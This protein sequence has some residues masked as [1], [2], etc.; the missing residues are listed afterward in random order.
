MCFRQGGDAER[1]RIE[2]EKRLNDFGLELALE[3][4][5]VMEFGPLARIQAK[6]K[7]KK[8]ATFDFLG[9]THYCSRTRD[10]RRFRMKRKTISKR[11]AAKVKAVKEWLKLNRT[12][13]TAELM[14]KLAAKLNGHYA[15]YGVT[16][17]SR[18]IANFYYVVC[19]L[20]HEW[21]NRRGKRG[22]YNWAKFN[23]LL[24]RYPLPTPRLKVN[25]F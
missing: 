16:D 14:K 8:A 15:Y 7:G 23:L 4:T 25:L 24:L 6:R 2:M 1:F 10:G 20:L 19:R 3:K 11:F 22:C 13:P 21:L 9:F 18:G 17:N 5:K 12:L